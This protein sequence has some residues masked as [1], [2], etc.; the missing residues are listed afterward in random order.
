MR[1]I[2]SSSLFYQF[3]SNEKVRMELNDVDVLSVERLD[4]IVMN[5][6]TMLRTCYMTKAGQLRHL[7]I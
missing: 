7:H 2:L 3:V 5:S 4:G 6:S 1:L